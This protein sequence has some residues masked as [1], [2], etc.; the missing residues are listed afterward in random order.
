MG[1]LR[2]PQRIEMLDAQLQFPRRDH[3]QHIAGALLKLLMAR[4]VMNQRGTRNKQGSFLREL[5]QVE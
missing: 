1:L 3:I 2:V 4:N 5:A